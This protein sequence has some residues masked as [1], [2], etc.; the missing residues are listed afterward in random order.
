MK[1]VLLVLGGK[2]EDNVPAAH[3]GLRADA[4]IAYYEEHFSREDI[5]FVVSGRWTN[6]TDSY[7]LTEAEAGK[8]YIQEQI[9]EADVYKEDVS[10]E[11]IGNFAFAKPIVS[12]FRPDKVVVFTSEFIL[13]RI[14][15]IGDRIF[16]DDVPTVYEV[17]TRD[18][19]DNEVLV[20]KEKAA[21]TLFD[22]VFAAVPDGDDSGFR[23]VLLYETPYYFKGIMS[24]REYFDKHW[25]GGYEAYLRALEVR[26]SL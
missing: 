6:V 11:L 16:S 2:V 23:D 24:D 5:T 17:I 9:P 22:V 10:V 12:R 3:F 13:P 26:D 8:R 19:S 20:L 7:E 14:T 21:L 15:R 4:A 1:T 18:L 25:E